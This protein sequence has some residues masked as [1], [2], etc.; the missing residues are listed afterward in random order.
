MAGLLHPPLGAGIHPRHADGQGRAPPRPTAV[1]CLLHSHGSLR[2]SPDAT[3]DEFPG[4][5]EI[6]PTAPPAGEKWRGVAPFFD[7]SEIDFEDFIRRWLQLSDRAPMVAASIAPPQSRPFLETALIEKCNAIEALA[8]S[9][10]SD[11][12]PHQKAQELAILHALE[13]AHVRSHD[14]KVVAHCLEQRRWQLEAKL[15]YAAESIGLESS[16]TLVGPVKHWAHLVMRVRNSVA[17]GSRLRSGLSDDI[18][19]LGDADRTLGAIVCLAAFRACG[20]TNGM[21]PVPGELLWSDSG[22]VASHPNSDFFNT[23]EALS[24]RSHLWSAWRERL[25]KVLSED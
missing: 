16:R 12:A 11:A 13:D 8:T 1:A 14:V 21:S 9:S 6:V 15:K 20:Y 7:T 25:D 10:W 4:R 18:S 22:Q 23:A 5:I 2:L 24:S 17:H 19:F 3:G